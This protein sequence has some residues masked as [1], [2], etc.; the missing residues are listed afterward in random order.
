MY[1]RQA[2]Q[3]HTFV[4]FVGESVQQVTLN[5]AAL[6]PGQVYA[7]SR[8]Q[9]GPLQADNTL[10]VV[11]TGRYTNSGEGL[12]RFV[13]PLDGEV[14]LYTQFEVPDARRVFAVFEQPL[15]LIHI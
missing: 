1:K 12:H 2:Q 9:I 8:L 7:D 14:Y 15:S 6:D 11:A 3:E 4:D 10:V 5:G 13:D